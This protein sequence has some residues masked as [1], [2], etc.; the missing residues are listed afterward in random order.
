ML[1]QVNRYWQTVLVVVVVV[2]L[3][4]S[5]AGT[6]ATYTLTRHDAFSCSNILFRGM[7]QVLFMVP[8][9]HCC[10]KTLSHKASYLLVNLHSYP[11]LGP[12]VLDSDQKD[13]RAN[14]SGGREF[15]QNGGCCLP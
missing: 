3:R 2:V 10:D 11:H 7:K 6:V 14:A 9:P 15:S 12:L 4:V 8:L 1:A 5:L 13:K